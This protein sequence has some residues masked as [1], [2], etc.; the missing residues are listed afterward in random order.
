MVGLV[1]VPVR[2]PVHAA[3][4]AASPE[5]AAPPRNARLETWDRTVASQK[6]SSLVRPLPAVRAG[7]S[8]DQMV[9]RG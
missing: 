8:M 7:P 9:L 5:A 6:R 4:R 1:V 2:P 3:S